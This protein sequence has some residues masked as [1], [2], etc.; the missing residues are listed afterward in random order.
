MFINEAS[1][2][3]RGYM[4]MLAAQENTEEPKQNTRTRADKSAKPVTIEDDGG[5]ETNPIRVAK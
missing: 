2:E 1:E 4:L 3:A 5:I